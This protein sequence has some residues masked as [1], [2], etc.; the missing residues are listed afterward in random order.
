MARIPELS[1]EAGL[2]QVEPGIPV[3]LAAAAPAEDGHPEWDGQPTVPFFPYHVITEA[4]AVMILLALYTFLAIFMPAHLDIK[5]DPAVTPEGS[6]P[7][8]YFLF[9]Y[10][11]LHFVPPLVGT[12]VPAVGILFLIAIP[13]LDRNPSRKPAERLFAITACVVLTIGIVGLS[14]LGYVE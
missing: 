2:E 11:F 4:T 8:W 12:L 14:I 6:K 9:L 1:R 5:S 10:A 7:E 13:W 3:G